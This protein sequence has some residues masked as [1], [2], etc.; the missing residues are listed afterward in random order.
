MNQSLLFDFQVDK[1]NKTIHVTREFDAEKQLVWD[2]WTKP[3]LLDQWW[4]PK[5][6]RAKTKSMDFQEGGTW[7]YAMVSP[8]GEHHWCRVDYKKIEPVVSFSALDAFCDENGLMN[9]AMPRSNWNNRF[10]ENEGTTTVDISITFE[11]LASL[12]KIIEMGFKEGFTMGLGN[13]D[14][15]LANMSNQKTK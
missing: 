5:P 3:E 12:E 4:A 9:D 1:E 11:D 8:E 2:A 6:W 13:L 7:L 15:L 10:T 14:E